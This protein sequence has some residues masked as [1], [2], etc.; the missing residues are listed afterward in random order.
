MVKTAAPDIV[1]A[2]TILPAVKRKPLLAPV[3]MV[4][5]LLAAESY[6]EVITEPEPNCNKRL[7]V[8]FVLTP[9]NMTVTRL[10]HDGMP[11]KSIEVPEVDATAVPETI[12]PPTPLTTTV[13]VP[14]GIV[15]MKLLAVV[16]GLISTDPPLA[17]TNLTPI[18][19]P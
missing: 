15:A 5:K 8:P 16:G 19:A 10:T 3:F 7:L 1:E 13:P 14:A 9:L 18:T 12:E 2:A 17:E 4:L 6:P 11:V